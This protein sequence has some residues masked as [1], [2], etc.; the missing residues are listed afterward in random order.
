MLDIFKPLPLADRRANLAAYQK[1]LVDRDGAVDVEKRHLSRR[2]ERM[3]R[4]ERPLSRIREIDRE[5]F[6]AQ[7]ASF[8][9]KVETPP[10][11]LLLVS[12][13]KINAAEAFGVNRNYERV[14]RRA[15]KN[16]DTCELTLLIEETYHTR[17]LLSTA[18]SYGVEVKSAYQPPTSLRALIST[19]AVSPMAIARPL[20]L[21]SEVLAILLFLNLLEKSR[22]VLR[23]DSELR[24][25]VEERLCEIITDEIGHMSFNRQC[26]GAVGIAQARLML[27]LV[28]AG[29]SGAFPELRALGTMS[30]ASEGEVQ[31]LASGERLP[32][33]VVR[34]AFLS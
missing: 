3:T 5:L 29:L 9:A 17:I 28:A 11:A 25:S 14:L 8:N 21:A 12:L 16:D 7:Y 19:I 13:V 30:S 18:L 26:L 6:T 2:E 32:E 27:P 24:D 10:E 22:V 1:F 34:N 4:Y 33:E 15:V 20:T 23:H 31:G